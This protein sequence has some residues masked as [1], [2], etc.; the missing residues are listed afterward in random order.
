MS[1]LPAILDEKTLSDK[2]EEAIEIEADLEDA[3]GEPMEIP[4]NVKSL[5][6]CRIL[7]TQ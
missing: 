7:P 5:S 2:L 6:K 4:K 1:K 3:D